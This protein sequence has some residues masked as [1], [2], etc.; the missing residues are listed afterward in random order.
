MSFQAIAATASPSAATK[1]AATTKIRILLVDDNHELLTGMGMLLNSFDDL[2]VIGLATDS[3]A[4]ITLAAEE[5]PDVIILDVDLPHSDGFKLGAHLAQQNPRAKLLFYSGHIDVRLRKKAALL[6][7]C[8]FLNKEESYLAIAQAVRTAHASRTRDLPA[9]NHSSL[10]CQLPDIFPIKTAPHLS[11]IHR[12]SLLS[13]KL[14]NAIL[15][16]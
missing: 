6:G 13:A 8:D 14:R 12:L 9:K 10:E 3:N 11:P 2:Q 1:K 15:A 5:N 16:H 7:A 4:A